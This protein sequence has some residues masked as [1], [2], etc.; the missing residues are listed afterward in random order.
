MA[1]HGGI[2]GNSMV[3]AHV[4]RAEEGGYWAEMP[5]DPGCY[6][7]GETMDELKEN[8]RARF[9]ALTPLFLLPSVSAKTGSTAFRARRRCRP[10]SAK[11]ISVAR[12]SSAGW[13]SG[14]YYAAPVSS[15]TAWRRISR[16]PVHHALEDPC[17]L[18][19]RDRGQRVLRSQKTDLHR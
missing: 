1:R 2:E 5:E 18:H 6:T 7:Q 17:T 15:I 11:A 3:T 19:G 13:V 9:G 4:Y 16:P 14:D 10:A 12:L 8:V